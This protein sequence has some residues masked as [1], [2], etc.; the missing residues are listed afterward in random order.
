VEKIVD[1]G[2]SADERAALEK[3]AASVRK[4]VEVVL[5]SGG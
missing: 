5:A 3:S 1:I 4:V 2:L